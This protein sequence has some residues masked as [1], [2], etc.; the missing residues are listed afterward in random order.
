MT[1]IVV[2]DGDKTVRRC[3]KRCYDAKHENCHCVC[4]GINHMKGYE[5]AQKNVTEH[6]Q[7]IKEK[8]EAENPDRVVALPEAK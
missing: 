4:N 8:F 5:Q 3:D 6:F 1:L 7:A 2:K